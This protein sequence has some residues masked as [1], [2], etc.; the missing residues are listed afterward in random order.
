AGGRGRL[1]LFYAT[2]INIEPPTFVVFVNRPDL[3]HFSYRRFMV[4]Q[5]REHFDLDHTPIKLVFRKR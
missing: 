1:K 3:V 2:Q 4:N 5:L